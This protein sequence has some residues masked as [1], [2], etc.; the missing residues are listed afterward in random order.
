MA[1]I[2]TDGVEIKCTLSDTSL[3]A[4]MTSLE[5]GDPDR[6]REIWFFDS[7]DPAHRRPRLLHAG[8]I[9]RLRRKKDGPGESTLKLRPARAE[10]LIGDFRAG[11]GRFG[12]R[13]SVE[14]DW[15]HEKVLAASMDADVDRNA[16]DE[17]AH[18]PTAAGFS[19]DQLRLLHEA[20]TPPSDPFTDI[21]AV[22]PIASKRWDDVGEGPLATLRAEH[23][24]Y[25]DG[26]KFLELSLKM[27][28]LTAAAQSRDALLDDL[29]LRGLK[30]D[31]AG[32]SKT[33]TVLMDLLIGPHRVR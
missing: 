18:E 24:T 10:L 16:A 17:M 15:A 33:E 29:A 1:D 9:L 6:K 5:L 3:D 32:M 31:P 25:G 20:G 26:R 4:A 28:D 19:V 14:W 13:Y 23:W 27:D 8:I 21:R 7:I 12:E 22:G 30:P 11:A 2:P